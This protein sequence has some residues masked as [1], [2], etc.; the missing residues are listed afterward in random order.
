DVIVRSRA[1]DGRAFY[2]TSADSA[3]VPPAV[4]RADQ[5]WEGGALA[6]P[7]VLSH[8][9]FL[10]YYAGMGAKRGIGVARSLDG[11]TFRKEPGPILEDVSGPAAY[12][13]EDGRFHLF[14][15]AGNSIGEAISDDGV[16]FTR[17]PDLVLAPVPHVA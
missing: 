7:F 12:V 5:P 2:G 17:L 15:S 8:G 14:F 10:L 9:G 16:R 1:L 6:G 11:T 3:H 4:L 13:G